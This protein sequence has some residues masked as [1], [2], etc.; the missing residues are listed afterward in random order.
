MSDEW[1][2]WVTSSPLSLPSA[3]QL[4]SLSLRLCFF[5][6][7]ALILF[8]LALFTSLHPSTP[9]VISLSLLCCFASSFSTPSYPS[10]L[11]PLWF[12]FVYC[13]SPFL[14][15]FFHPFMP[16]LLL[17]LFLSPSLSLHTHRHTST[18]TIV[19]RSVL[20]SSLA[21]VL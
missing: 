14:L 6:F 10:P 3:T 20:S 8:S 7:I 5:F 13:Q 4:L 16:L 21:M 2:P 19:P 9:Q 1:Q 12:F 11:F 15:F 18:C 17:L